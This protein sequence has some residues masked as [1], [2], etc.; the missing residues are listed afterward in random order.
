MC[1]IIVKNNR[2][3]FDSDT[4]KKSARI[5]PHGLG[6]VWL[7]NY[8]ITYHKSSEYKVITNTTRPFIAHFRYATIGKIGKSNTHPFQCGKKESEYLM[9]N[10]TIKNL[11]DANTCDTK[12]LANNLG[13]L[14]RNTWKDV[15]KQHA[16]RFVSVNVRN[17]TFQI[18][19]KDLWTIKDDVWFSKPNVIEDNYVAVYGTLKKNY[20]NYWWYLGNSTHVGKGKTYEKFPLIIRSLPFL[21]NEEGKGH[22]VE[23]DLFKVTDSTLADL[24]RLEGHPHWYRREQ[25]WVVVKGEPYLAWIYFNIKEKSDGEV[26]HKSYNQNN[27]Y[28]SVSYFDNGY[29]SKKSASP[30]TENKTTYYFENT[31]FNELSE[32]EEKEFDVKNEK[33]MCINCFHDLEWDGFANYFCNGCNDWFGEKEVKK[34]IVDFNAFSHDNNALPF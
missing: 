30:G 31:L 28:K 22:N 13:D 11:G 21:I 19:N 2:K 29:T 20:S 24:D 6:V 17:K 23:I 27:T 14:P 18:Y 5:N 3:K 10:G 32:K 9:M 8:K 16:C 26:L 4:A 7:D 33:P 25:V 1:V 34:H 15:L 12:V